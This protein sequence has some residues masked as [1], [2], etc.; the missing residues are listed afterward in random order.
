MRDDSFKGPTIP[1]GAMVEY[2]PISAADQSWLHQ[3]GEKVL[4]GT[5]LGYALVAGGIGKGAV[6]VVDVE[7][8]ERMDALEVHARRLNVKE[9]LT[10]KMVKT[11][12]GT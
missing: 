10:P 4:P 5:F 9:V 2:H 3:F 7:E 11:E 6:L 12:L 8:L 1:F